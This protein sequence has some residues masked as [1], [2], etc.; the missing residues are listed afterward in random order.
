MKTCSVWYQR[1]LSLSTGNWGSTLENRINGHLK[2][3]RR[4]D[5]EANKETQKERQ[6]C[7]TNTTSVHSLYVWWFM[8]TQE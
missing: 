5:W 4:K 6:R 1:Q 3:I 2:T 8:L 7:N